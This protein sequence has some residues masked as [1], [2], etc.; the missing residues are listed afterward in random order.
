M[1]IYLSRNRVLTRQWLKFRR[2][3][4]VTAGVAERAGFGRAVLRTALGLLGTCLF[5]F[6]AG[7][8][9][10]ALSL[11]RV[12]PNLTVKAEGVVV[13]TGGSDRVLEAAG[14]FAQGQGKRML[15]TG[16]NRATRSSELAKLLPVPRD[17]FNCC[18]DLGYQALDTIGNARETRE[19]A[20]VHNISRS[21]I[22]VTSNYHMPR[23]LAEL[24]AELPDIKL[25]PFPVVSEH[26]DVSDWAT[27]LRV[28]RLVGG[29]YL[30]FLGALLRITVRE[31][32]S[33]L[34]QAKLRASETASE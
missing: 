17:L 34:E 7:F 24:A 21:L 8:I 23:A 4:K 25:Y 27:D 15:I 29:E 33:A 28:T 31:E 9:W 11:A 30:K 26:V 2:C 14:L 20:Q 19:W 6:A 16:V 5:L 1:T 13:F 18:V 3:G 32:E 12:E 10:F 22:V